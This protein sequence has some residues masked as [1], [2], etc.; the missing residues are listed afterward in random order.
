MLPIEIVNKI[1]LYIGELN[2]TMMITQYHPIT[3]KE[4]YMINFNSDLLW[5]I[6]SNLIMKR[7]YPVYNADNYLKTKKFI[8]LYKFGI[9]HYENQLRKSITRKYNKIDK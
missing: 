6:K 2:N 5:R 4:Y 1:L 3:N 8:E 7:V 9:P